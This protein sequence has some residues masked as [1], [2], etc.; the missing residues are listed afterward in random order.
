[1]STNSNGAARFLESLRN[2]EVR[3]D[4]L[5]PDAAFQALEVDVAGRDSVIARMTAE[6]TGQIYRLVTWESPVEN[7]DVLHIRGTLPAGERWGGIILTLHF[8]GDLLSVIQQQGLP[9]EPKPATSIKLSDGLKECV[10]IAWRDRHPILVAHT[11]ETGQPIVSY[12]GSLQAFS[13]DQ[14]ALWVRNPNGSFIRSIA[15]NPKLGLMYRNEDIKATY[16]FQGRARIVTDEASRTQIFQTM[17]QRER[18]HDYAQIGVAVIIDLD[19]VEG[20]AGLGPNGHIDPIRQM[21]GTD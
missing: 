17:I 4:L 2:G 19:Y 21:R 10:N 15:L 3:A 16:T 5:T 13:D 11:D 7:G 1:M 9:G 18:D 12:R 14:L 8:E 20:R 6:T